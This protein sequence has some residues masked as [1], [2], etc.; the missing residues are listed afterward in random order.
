MTTPS[1]MSEVALTAAGIPTRGGV[2]P[3]HLVARTSATYVHLLP[4]DLP[5]PPEVPACEQHE[6]A[7][8]AIRAG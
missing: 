6:A 8:E 1:R 5:E 2:V 3:S 7:V 4:Q